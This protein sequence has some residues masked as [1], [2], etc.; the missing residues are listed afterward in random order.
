[1]IKSARASDQLTVY[2]S[3]EIDHHAA[4]TIR[5][6]I[7][8]LLSDPSIK[9][10]LFDFSKVSFMDSSGIGMIIGRY[11]TMKAR[12]GRAE[13]TGLSDAVMRIYRLGGLHRIIPVKEDGG[14]DE[15]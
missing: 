13:A 2:L 14:K 4:S 9:R 6:D 12:N 15:R 1:M 5:D 3:G 8:K 11:K 7:E 10:L